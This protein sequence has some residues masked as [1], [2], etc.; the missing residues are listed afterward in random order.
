MDLWSVDPAERLKA[1]KK[2]KDTAGLAAR[3]GEHAPMQPWPYGMPTSVNPFVLFL[4][5]SPGGS[6]PIGEVVGPYQ[7]PTCGYPHPKLLDVR[8]RKGYW[9]RVRELGSAIVKARCRTIDDTDAHALIGH[10][11][12]GVVQSG[13]A[14]EAK[15]E[16][17]YCDF[18]ERAVWE[19]L[20]PRHVVLLGLL[21]VLT[22]A[23]R[24]PILE[25]WGIDWKNP[26][27]QFR[28]EA[29]TTKNY[30]FR[31]WHRHLPD[32]KPITFAMWPNH[33]SRSPMTKGSIWQASG[34]EFVRRQSEFG[35]A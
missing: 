13:K 9:N 16:Q 20:C 1:A 35:I 30:Y 2:F 14:A 18:V 27:D 29:Y 19:Y 7:L 25:R 21:D 4:G 32:G 11:N 22:G 3:F 12:L 10:L 15:I 34:E 17:K 6:P 33:P 24:P 28:F 26:D 31:L 8:D 23:G 5:A